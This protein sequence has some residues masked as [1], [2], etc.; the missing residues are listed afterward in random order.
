MGKHVLGTLLVVMLCVTG[1]LCVQAEC[2]DDVY[3]TDEESNHENDID[4]QDELLAAKTAIALESLSIT[5]NPVA[6]VGKNTKYKAAFSPANATGK[7]VE[8]SVS[9]EGEGVTISSGGHLKVAADC[10]LTECIATVTSKADAS[11]SASK[12]VGIN[13]A[14][15]Q[16]INIESDGKTING[17][18]IPLFTTPGDSDAPMYIDTEPVIT[19]RGNKEVNVCPYEYFS[20]NEDIVTVDENGRVQVTGNGCGKVQIVCRAIDGTKDD[21][22]NALAKSFWVNVSDSPVSSVDI[23]LPEG[24]TKYVAKG[25]KIKLISTVGEAFGKVTNKGVVYTSSETSA[26]TVDSYGNVTMKTDSYVPVTITATAA[27]GRRAFGKV[28]LIACNVI[29][30]ISLGNISYNLAN[31]NKYTEIKLSDGPLS[32]P[33]IFNEPEGGSA[34]Q[35]CVSPDLTVTS[36]MKDCLEVS[37]EEGNVII[38]PKKV[39]DKKD[40]L[41]TVKSLDG[42]GFS[43]N[44]RFRIT[45]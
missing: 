10:K 25:K 29:K 20:R 38:D 14:Y 37:Y 1:T 16:S 45:D 33:V 15:I 28:E 32:L 2:P 34:Y 36:N 18:T 3:I 40:I 35:K 17:K 41:V 5:G 42:S 43:R 39:C 27:D 26:A 12:V 4:Y 24:R 8:W 44:F 31:T 22:G 6:V 13:P 19:L 7:A 23:T 11:I 30:N 21:N 9:P